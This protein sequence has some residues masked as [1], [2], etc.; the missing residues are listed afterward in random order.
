MSLESAIHAGRLPDPAL[1]MSTSKRP[2]SLSISPR[3]QV[4]RS[5][6]V[7]SHTMVEEAF[8]SGALLTELFEQIGVS[9][10]IR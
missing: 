6:S 10:P 2:L 5:V 9:S 3:T 4:K 8:E 7:T 1:L